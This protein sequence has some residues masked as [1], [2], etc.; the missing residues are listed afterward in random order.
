MMNNT[1]LERLLF[2]YRD[3]PSDGGGGSGKTAEEI[4][5]ERLETERLAAEQDAEKYPGKSPEEIVVLKKAEADEEAAKNKGKSF[6]QK[7]VDD[8]I[9]ARLKRERDAAEKKNRETAGEFEKLYTEAKPQLEALTSEVESLRE[10][11]NNNID[12]IIKDWDVD[13]RS[14]DPGNTDLK[15]RQ[16]WVEKSSKLAARLAGKKSPVDGEPGN[17]TNK[18][19]GKS[20]VNAGTYM[21]GNYKGPV[22]PGQK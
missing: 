5:T 12:T 11:V 22:I 7:E 14:Q 20:K 1:R 15:V 21:A 18:D 16:A 17:H 9:A 19:G 2:G 6:N 13:L 4:E 3:E 10:I 8:I